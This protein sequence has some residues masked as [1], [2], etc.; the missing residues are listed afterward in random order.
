MA[1]LELNDRGVY[2]NVPPGTNLEED[3]GVR[4]EGKVLQLGLTE[5][6]IENVWERIE[7]LIEDV[8]DGKIPVF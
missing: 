3:E 2:S 4:I 1:Q 7:H 5:D 8:D 6:E